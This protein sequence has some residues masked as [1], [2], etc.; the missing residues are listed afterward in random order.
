MYFID[1]QN[2]SRKQFQINTGSRRIVRRYINCIMHFNR[3]C[4]RQLCL[5]IQTLEQSQIWL[6]QKKK[7]LIILQ[8]WNFYYFYFQN[9][10][11]KMKYQYFVVIQIEHQ[12]I[13]KKRIFM[14]I[15]K[16]QIQLMKLKDLLDQ[17]EF[18]N[19]YNKNCIFNIQK[20]IRLMSQNLSQF[21]I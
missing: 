10:N 18:Q 13:V 15:I 8:V 17:N 2:Q 6:D 4:N 14:V 7:K 19:I 3:G 12:K 20:L 11:F 21:L 9:Q 16:Q 5:I 1:L